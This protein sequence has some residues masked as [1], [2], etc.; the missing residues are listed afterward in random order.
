MNYRATQHGAL[1]QIQSPGMIKI[2]WRFFYVLYMKI[3]KMTKKNL[4]MLLNLQVIIEPKFRFTLFCFKELKKDFL[5]K[6]IHFKSYLSKCKNHFG[7]QQSPLL[8]K[9]VLQTQNFTI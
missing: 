6:G 2:K 3:S 5:K 1:R 9:V 4:L 8:N 7:T